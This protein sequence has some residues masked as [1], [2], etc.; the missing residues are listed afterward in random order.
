MILAGTDTHAD[1]ERPVNG[2]GTAKE[3]A[4]M[5]GDEVRLILD[6]AGTEWI[7]ELEDEAHDVHDPYRS[8]RG[9]A[10]ASSYCAGAFGVVDA[11]DDAGV[12]TLD[13]PDGRP[14]VRSLVDDPYEGITV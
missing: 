13:A 7:P 9:E 1:L 12:S 3:L 6:G 11:V 8:L 5:P 10:A 14:S 4:E 2:L